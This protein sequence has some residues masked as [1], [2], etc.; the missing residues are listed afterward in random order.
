[1]NR[2][3]FFATQLAFLTSTYSVWI[4]RAAALS[5]SPKTR[6]FLIF[7]GTDSS[8]THQTLLQRARDV[9]ANQNPDWEKHLTTMDLQVDTTAVNS[10]IQLYVPQTTSFKWPVLIGITE[11]EEEIQFWS[12][13]SL[14]ADWAITDGCYPLNSTWWSVE[15]DMNPTIEKVR[16]HLD[17]SFNHMTGNFRTPW[18][19][20]LQFEEL[21]SLHSDHHREMSW[22]G[23]VYWKYVNRQCPKTRR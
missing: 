12:P 11:G 7:D 3:K 1:M 16:N 22:M 4:N 23:R 9:I 19:N 14:R 10:L 15:G 8:Q 20:L 2:R 6:Y 13:E 5:E 21:Q 17:R 18:L